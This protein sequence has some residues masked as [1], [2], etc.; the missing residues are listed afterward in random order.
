[1][2]GP[3]CVAPVCVDDK[4]LFRFEGVG[5]GASSSRYNWLD[6]GIDKLPTGRFSNSSDGATS[7]HDFAQRQA[8]PQSRPTH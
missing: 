2:L 1:M 8:S 3:P 5:L 7:N 6:V 4:W